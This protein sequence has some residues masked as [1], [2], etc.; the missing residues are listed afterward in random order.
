MS[1]SNIGEIAKI[2]EK[3]NAELV[4]STGAA[5]K[6]LGKALVGKDASEIVKALASLNYGDES[7]ASVL[8]AAGIATDVATDSIRKFGNEGAKAGKKI[9]NAFSGVKELGKKGLSKLFGFIVNPSNWATIGV[10]ATV[11]AVAIAGYVNS[12][13]YLNKKA[14]ESQ[15][16]YEKTASELQQMNDEF[17]ENSEKLTELNTIKAPTLAEQS[18]I[19]KLQAANDLLEAQIGLKEK[20]LESDKKEAA[21]DA[22]DALTK[23]FLGADN[24]IESVAKKKNSL[25]LM[26]SNLEASTKLLKGM[27]PNSAEYDNE[28]TWMNA[29]KRSIEESEIELA[30]DKLKLFGLYDQLLGD[31]ES[32][33]GTINSIKE[34]FPEID[35]SS[36]DLSERIQYIKESFYNSLSDDGINGNLKNQLSNEFSNWIDGLSEEDQRLVYEIYCDADTAKYSLED[37]KNAL[38][39]AKEASFDNISDINKSIQSAIT[40]NTEL[41]SGISSIREIINAQTTGTSL[42][43]ESFNSSE[44]KEYASALEYVNGALQLNAEKVNGI[45]KSKAK[46]QIA[47]NDSNKALAQAKYLENAARIEELRQDLLDSSKYKTQAHVKAIE[48]SIASLE[49]QNDTLLDSCKSYELMSASLREA[50]SAYQHWINAQNSA[51]SGDMFDGTIDAINRID[52]TINDRASEYYG[53][54]GRSD[55]KAALDLIIPDH[56]DSDDQAAVQKYLEDISGY[57]TY[58]GQGNRAG[59][60]IE[61]FCKRAVEEGLMVL[62]DAGTDYEIAGGKTMEDFASGLG[63]ALPLVQAMFG[64]MQEFGG[65]FDWSDEV[66]KTIGDLAVSAVEAREILRGIEGNEN[67]EIVLDVNDIEDGQE[68]IDALNGTIDQ[69]QGII[70]LSTDPTEISAAEDIIRHCIAQKQLLC[71]PDIMKVDTTMVDG[72]LGSAI[73]KIQEFVAIQNQIELQTELGV[74]TTAAK[75]SLA[76]VANEISAINPNILAELNVDTTSLETIE[77]SIRTLE[78]P[79]I[80]NAGVKEDAII[81]HSGE[82]TQKVKVIYTKDSSEVDGYVPSD[83]NPTVTYRLVS[84]AVD[85]YDPKN[86]D[87][88]VTYHIK[89]KG[90][91]GSLFGGGH[92]VNGTAHASGTACAGGNWGKAVGGKTLVGEL[93]REIVVD[94]HTGRWYTVGDF[95]AEFRDIPR[96]AIVFNHKQSDSLL[97]NGYVAGRASALVG[98]TAMVG[99]GISVNAVSASKYSGGYTPYQSSA[100]SSNSKNSK[101]A[102][103]DS[104]DWIE[105]AIK[106]I[107]D[108]VKRLTSAA[109]SAY[110]SLKSKLGFTVDQIALVNEELE[111]QEKA[112]TRYM[113]QANSVGLSSDL[114]KLVQTG[115]VDISE[116]DKETQELIKDYQN[117]YEKA[118]ECSNAIE[119][120]HE[121]LAELYEDNFNNIQE[122]FDNQLELL[123][124]L[125]NSY[126]NQLDVLEAKGYMESAEYYEALQ[127]VERKKIEVLN[128]ELTALEK[129]FSDAMNSGEIE[130]GSDA[131]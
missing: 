45:I 26:K 101:D 41:V 51:Q 121:N 29:L 9:G 76:N 53:R 66:E 86:L 64:E 10:A 94:P 17:A 81:G 57:F 40:D 14:E 56:I 128:N 1:L 111:L 35:K 47:I 124:H 93:G 58:D 98:G 108:A 20:L 95:G 109:T 87:R 75:E 85:S 82:S 32:Y 72:Q 113:E 49:A 102:E 67:L 33:K 42:S 119:D 118:N 99:G 48:S 127:D 110:K 91:V 34:L 28:L 62:N 116:Y 21:K 30:E 11:G 90:F 83:H 55:Y 96:G 129:S 68:K 117:W 52:D 131:W 73:A 74:D 123:E 114:A 31:E 36:S 44:L 8:K 105:V 84:T 88:D 89:T 71:Q 27:D 106:R 7:I 24:F 50:T 6:A 59:L 112:Y 13:D 15:A 104:F 97:K 130:E 39:D 120:L 77:S 60:N 126:E 122:D 25:D 65:V 22:N 103:T 43:A 16:V 69:M 107:E 61:Q 79:A 5:N 78:I 19:A 100:K 70:E 38:T 18:E 115:A 125:T 37:W 12:F 54:V 3:I 4:S 23:S 92:D 2:A 46:E 63:L 80:I